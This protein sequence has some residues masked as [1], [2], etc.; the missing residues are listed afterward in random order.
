[1][2]APLRLFVTLLLLSLIAIPLGAQAPSE[3]WM[4]FETEH[5]RVHFPAEMEEWARKVTSR[6]ESVREIVGEKV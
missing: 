1:M 4:T 5:Y 6:L 3:E 2:R